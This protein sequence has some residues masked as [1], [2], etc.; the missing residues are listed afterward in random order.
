M[1]TLYA[2]CMVYVP[3]FT[4][5]HLSQFQMYAYSFAGSNHQLLALLGPNFSTLRCFFFCQEG[6]KIWSAERS[7][8]TILRICGD[9]VALN[10]WSYQTASW[11]PQMLVKSKGVLP[12]HLNSAWGLLIYPE[13][14]LVG[15]HMWEF[16]T[17]SKCALM[18]AGMQ[19]LFISRTCTKPGKMIGKYGK[20]LLFDK[21]LSLFT[22][23][24]LKE[25]LARKG[26]SFKTSWRYF[27][28]SVGPDILSSDAGCLYC[29][30][31]TR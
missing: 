4:I 2:P 10:T 25:V 19:W 7:T 22:C 13:I 17:V 15:D 28:L 24:V 1:P 31:Y 18:Q 6:S 23:L 27:V 26:S 8:A 9:L 11:S 12:N 21:V 3:T 16:L 14:S 29:K 20:S 30:W 5:I